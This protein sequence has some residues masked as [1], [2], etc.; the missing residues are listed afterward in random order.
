MLNLFGTRSS[1]PRKANDV[2]LADIKNMIKQ[3]KK[4]SRN[5]EKELDVIYMKKYCIM[6]LFTD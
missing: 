2:V 4:E 1:E 6:F 5:V 3:L